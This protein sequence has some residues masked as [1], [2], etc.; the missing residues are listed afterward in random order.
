MSDLIPIERIES[1][2]MLIRGK[3]VLLDSDLAVLYDVPVGRLNEAVKRK[4]KRFPS[5]FMFQL[6]NKEFTDLKSQFAIANV[7]RG[8]RRTPPY[9]FTEQGVAMLSSVLNSERAIQVNITIMNTFVNMRELLL[10]NAKMSEKLRDIEDRMDTQEM[11][12]IIIMDKLRSLNTPSKNK[13]K[14]IGFDTKK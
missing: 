9:A 13:V 7:G 4:I 14:K 1:K 6:N 8:G 5:N 12:T 11:N 3:K 2:I 10:N